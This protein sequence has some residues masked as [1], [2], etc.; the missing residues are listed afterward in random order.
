MQN[1]ADLKA[2]LIYQ[3]ARQ[4]ITAGPEGTVYH[5]R[6]REQTAEEAQGQAYP[7]QGLLD[8]LVLQAARHGIGP[9]IEAAYIEKHKP[10]AAGLPAGS[11]SADHSGV[12]QHQ[13]GRKPRE[14]Q[15]YCRPV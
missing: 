14:R 2:E 13:P 7:W 8:E 6:Y 9:V 5:L 4:G 10:E 3:L 11:G 1:A 15:P 12:G